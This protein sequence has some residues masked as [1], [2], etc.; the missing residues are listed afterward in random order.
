MIAALY[1][2]VDNMLDAI[3]AKAASDD[4]PA[5]QRIERK[6]RVNDQ[7]YFV[8][9]WGQIEEAIDGACRAAIRRGQALS[10]WRNR[11][12]WM[13][14]NPDEPRLSGL[15]FE[16]RAALVLERGGTPNHFATA[17]RHYNVRNQIAHGTLLSERIDV[18]TVVQDFYLV[19]S[20][21]AT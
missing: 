21:L 12:A 11:R 10:G 1:V 7:A 20:S 4:R 15:R 17:M 6:L 18:S 16:D 14:Y 3:R 9:A 5:V 8:L 19:Q 2:E 13:L